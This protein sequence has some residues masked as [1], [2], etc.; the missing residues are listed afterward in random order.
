MRLRMALLAL[1]VMAAACGGAA[2]AS[3]ETT[4]SSTA[5][6]ATTMEPGMGSMNM[7]DPTA[8][9][10]QEIAGAELVTGDFMPLASAPDGFDELAGS[11]AM[12][13]HSAGT[14][15]TIEFANLV[16]EVDFVAHV[17][18]GTC[19]DSGGP[20]YQFDENGSGMPPNEIHLRFASTSDGAGSMTA[21]NDQIAGPEATS[22]VVHEMTD[23][24]PKIACADLS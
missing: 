21:E 22:V 3:D 11:A 18:A 4:S 20:H 23:D 16:P 15:V 1:A 2:S 17:H 12:A 6:P 19:F 5:D 8:T 14:T 13:R 9:P 10:A 24:A 7:G